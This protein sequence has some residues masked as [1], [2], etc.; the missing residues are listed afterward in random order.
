MMRWPIIL[1]SKPWRR[2]LA[3][4]ILLSLICMAAAW[5]LARG[6][7]KP[8]LTTR[9]VE[10]ELH[11]LDDGVVDARI[12]DGRA[13]PWAPEQTLKV[14]YVGL[15]TDST[16][17]GD[18][19]FSVE[20]R[21]KI[22][23]SSRAVVM[24]SG[25]RL[26]PDD[27]QVVGYMIAADTAFETTLPGRTPYF[28][29]Q[30]GVK[31][32]RESYDERDYRPAIF[33]ALVIVWICMIA[34]CVLLASLFAL[35]ERLAQS[36]IRRQRCWAAAAMTDPGARS[37]CARSVPKRTSSGSSLVDF[38][39]RAIALVAIRLPFLLGS[40]CFVRAVAEGPV[41]ASTRSRR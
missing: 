24:P 4:A 22:Y 9:Q 8:E 31:T 7:G 25:E 15:M 28:L 6:P 10:V 5:P 38:L 32:W 18:S 2:V 37:S 21:T 17:V 26:E 30:R 34:A 41:C 3:L 13:S 16:M 14:I 36:R 11:V 19:R 23:W 12:V 29:W 40:A 35:R 1:R 20:R 39:S 27:P 33:A